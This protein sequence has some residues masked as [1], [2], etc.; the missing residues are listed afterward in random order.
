I[1]QLYGTKGYMAAS[2][3]PAPQMDDQQ[4]TVKYAIAVHEGDVYKMGD[5]NIEGLDKQTTARVQEAWRLRGGD[6]YDS[7]YPKRFL[8]ETARE[9]EGM[10]AWRISTREALDDKDK[11]VDVTLRYDPKPR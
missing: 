6:P 1:R 10:G 5:L 7:S 8:E 9:I 3:H 11:V 2:L 4:A